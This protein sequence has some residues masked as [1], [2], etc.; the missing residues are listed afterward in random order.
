[1][2]TYVDTSALVKWYLNEACSDDV[3]AYL[4]IAPEPTIST[5]T[6]VEMRC[7]LARHRLS[8]QLDA[9]SERRAFAQFESD[10]AQGFLALI[11][12]EDSHV[13]AASR[14]I[15]R[16]Q[17]LVLRTLDALHLAIAVGLQ[18]KELATADRLMADAAEELGLKVARF[19]VDRH[20]PNGYT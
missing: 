19:E 16:V 6:V 4:R 11:A 18:M 8:R 5:L 12:V 14:M 17:P 15:E 20:D 7:L 9:A 3:E 13:L 1:M 10:I 2:S